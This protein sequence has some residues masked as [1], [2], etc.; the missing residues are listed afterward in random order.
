MNPEV[1]TALIASSSAIIGTFV[2]VMI[3]YLSTS[4]QIK[5]EHKK[6]ENAKID[7]ASELRLH[8]LYVPLLRKLEEGSPPDEFNPSTTVLRQAVKLVDQHRMFASSKLLSKAWELQECLAYDQ[9]DDR[10]SRELL[11]IA[12]KEFNFFKERLGFI[13]I[14]T[15]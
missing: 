11:D 7:K 8:N 3:S 14:E 5:A 1:Q 15:K 13:D 2:G 9:I 6:I 10:S 4:R 12:T